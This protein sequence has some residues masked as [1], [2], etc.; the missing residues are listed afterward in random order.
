MRGLGRG[1]AG[2]GGVRRRGRGR[3][4]RRGCR[5][6][7]D[8]D[9]RFR[10]RWWWCLE[11]GFLFLNIALDAV[12][13]PR[14]ELHVFSSAARKFVLAARRRW[15]GVGCWVGRRG[16]VSVGCGGR[17][18]E[19]RMRSLRRKI[20]NRALGGLCRLWSGLLRGLG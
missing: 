19:L 6:M 14:T 8:G 2:E 13:A 1:N 17:A 15:L 3:G 10:G 5:A 20:R 4:V 7:F 12:L 18:W 9:I 16:C 11:T